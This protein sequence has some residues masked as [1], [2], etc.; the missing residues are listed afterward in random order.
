MTF[1]SS[2]MSEEKKFCFMAGLP[3]SGS[4]LLSSILNQNPRVYSSPSSP[5]L[6]TIH[7]IEDHLINN[8]LYH[9]FPKPYEVTNII[10]SIAPQYYGDIDKPVIIDKNRAWPSRIPLARSYITQNVKIIVPVRDID[11]I[12]TSMIMMIR[13]NPYKEGNLKI[14]FIDDQLVKQNIPLTDDNRCEFLASPNGIVG[15]SLQSI[16]D[17]IEQGFIDNLHFVE[18]KNLIKRPATELKKI[19]QFLG[20]EPF[21]HSFKNIENINR[22]NDMEVYGLSD[23]HEIRSELK[24]TAPNPSEILSDY[25]LERCKGMD[26]WRQINYN[27]SEKMVIRN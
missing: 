22:E 1:L 3:R 19:Y 17:A 24:S 25:I 21:K 4:T 12:L 23:M 2:L 6:S 13:R 27:D 5:V 15:Q 18:Y 10:Q 16:I 20:E 9:G 14:N 7:V 11:E 26:I 8:E